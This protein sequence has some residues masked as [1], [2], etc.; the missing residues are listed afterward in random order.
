MKTTIKNSALLAVALVSLGATS[1]SVLAATASTAKSIGK[2]KFLPNDG[3]TTPENPDDP[4]TPGDP[5][6]P[7]KD[8]DDPNHVNPIDPDDPGNDGSGENDGTGNKGPLSL[9]YVSNIDFG[10]SKTNAGNK[11]FLAKN[12]D[13]FVQVTDSREAG[14]WKLTA[15]LSKPFTNSTNGSMLKGAIMEWKDGE[16]VSSDNNT[17]IAPT[18][19]A[20]VQL[21]DDGQAVNF[22]TDNEAKGK[23]AGKGTWLDRFKKSGTQA[24]TTG[25]TEDLGDNTKVQ[26]IVPGGIA[27]AGTYTGEIT[28]TL[29]DTIVE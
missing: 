27:Q 18:A 16:P 25:D 26:L 13:P 19:T 21:G 15:A 17:S 3:A 2:I 24:G 10:T 29:A 11:H 28:W 4:N 22:M 14:S 7:G 12:D 5:D 1:S 23:S 20:D 9:D 6:Y 8:P